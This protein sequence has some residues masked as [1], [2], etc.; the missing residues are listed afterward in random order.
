MSSFKGL[1]YVKHENGEISPIKV[2]TVTGFDFATGKIKKYVEVNMTYSDVIDLTASDD[3]SSESMGTIEFDDID[4]D[5]L[6]D[7]SDVSGDDLSVPSMNIA[8][9][10]N[11]GT[12]FVHGTRAHFFDPLLAA[13]DPWNNQFNDY[14]LR[15]DQDTE[16]VVSRMSSE[17]DSSSFRCLACAG[18]SRGGWR[19]CDECEKAHFRKRVYVPRCG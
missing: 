9:Q 8:S 1:T 14:L 11:S 6:S 7:L 2:S 3:S 17:E 10:A 16:T 5:D 12:S 19:Y 4:M 18:Q 15:Y 13:G